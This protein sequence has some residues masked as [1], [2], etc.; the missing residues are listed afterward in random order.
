[1]LGL[2][3]WSNT[4][5]HTET[6]L[7]SHTSDHTGESKENIASEGTGARGSLGA[8]LGLR[9]RIKFREMM[10]TRGQD[11]GEGDY[12]STEEGRMTTSVRTRG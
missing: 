8:Y 5:K 12:G 9:L 3:N 2:G 1:M 10:G 7:A 11:D 6:Q 4:Q